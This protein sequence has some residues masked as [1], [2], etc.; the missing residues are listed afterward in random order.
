[1]T[2]IY[3]YIYKYNAIYN[4][5]KIQLRADEKHIIYTIICIITLISMSKSAPDLPETFDPVWGDLPESK[6]LWKS[7]LPP[8]RDQEACGGCYAFAVT[9]ALSHRICISTNGKYSP[10]LSVHELIAC[11]QYNYGC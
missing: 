10:L 4:I 7:C 3:I 2:I 1:M 11:D 9:T 5:E 8:I 6:S